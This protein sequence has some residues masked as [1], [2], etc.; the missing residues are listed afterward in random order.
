MEQWIRDRVQGAQGGRGGGG[1]I[2][3]IHGSRDFVTMRGGEKKYNN[4]QWLI[5]LTRG[6]S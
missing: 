3:I 4:Q 5:G 1:G 6:D 2:P